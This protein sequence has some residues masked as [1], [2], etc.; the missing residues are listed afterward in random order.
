[1]KLYVYADQFENFDDAVKWLDENISNWQ[2]NSIMSD[3]WQLLEFEL[4]GHFAIQIADENDVTIA[5]MSGNCS[6]H[7]N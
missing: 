5:I 7:L 6:R 4:L 2:F 3:E 1:M